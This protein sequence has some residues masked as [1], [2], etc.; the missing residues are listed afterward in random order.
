MLGT[1]PDITE[2]SKEEEEQEEEAPAAE[3]VPTEDNLQV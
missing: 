1:T 2:P 3:I